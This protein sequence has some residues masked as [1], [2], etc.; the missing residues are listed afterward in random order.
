MIQLPTPRRAARW[1][2]YQALTA[3]VGAALKLAWR[4]LTRRRSR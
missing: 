2:A 3:A 1:L 4:A